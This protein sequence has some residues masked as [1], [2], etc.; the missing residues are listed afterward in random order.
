MLYVAQGLRLR[1]KEPDLLLRGSYHPMKVEG[2]NADHVIAF[3][4]EYHGK[5][6]LTIAARWFASLLPEP[7]ALPDLKKNFQQTFVEI[8]GINAKLAKPMKFANVLTGATVDAEVDGRRDAV[9]SWR[10]SGKL[11]CGVADRRSTI[12]DSG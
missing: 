7:T 3:A 1:E 5:I 9:E 12:A 10:Q 6:L 4:R 8:P 2:P 11:A